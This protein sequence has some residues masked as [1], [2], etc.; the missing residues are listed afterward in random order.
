[1][2]F[3]KILVRMGLK[4]DEDTGEF[5]VPKTILSIVVVE[6]T[7]DEIDNP[8]LFGVILDEVRRTLL[9]LGIVFDG[10]QFRRGSVLFKGLR[11]ANLLKAA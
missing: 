1:M 9:G 7:E 6:F 10:Y 5:I 8:K 4:R 3:D 2:L 11:F